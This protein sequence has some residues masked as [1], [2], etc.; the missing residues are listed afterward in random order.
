MDTVTIVIRHDPT[1]A[2]WRIVEVF[3]H[4]GDAELYVSRQLEP[5]T[6]E[7]T[8]KVVKPNDV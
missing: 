2:G 5:L 4:Y 3:K 1:A 7:L 8:Q 6:Y